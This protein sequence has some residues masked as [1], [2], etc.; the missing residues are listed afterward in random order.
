MEITS[1]D[2]SEKL[3]PWIRSQLDSA[4]QTLIKLQV[5]EGALIEVKPAWT[6]PF[7]LLIGKAREQS[8]ARNF[9]WFICGDIPLDHLGSAAASTPREAAKHFAMKWQLDAARLQD[10]SSETLIE[11]AEALY[12]LADDDNLWANKRGL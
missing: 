7:Q 3:Q 11:N 5:F 12:A 8:D 1:N 10:D 2:I 9:R 6:L 4:V